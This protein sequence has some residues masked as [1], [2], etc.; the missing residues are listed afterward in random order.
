MDSAE[1][2]DVS[3]EAE[4]SHEGILVLNQPCEYCKVLS[5]DDSEYS[6]AMRQTKT[7][8]PSIDF[9]NALETRLPGQTHDDK[10]HAH[11]QTAFKL[12]YERRD[13]LPDLPGLAATGSQG[14]AF[15]DILRKDI[16]SAWVSPTG[17]SKFGHRDTRANITIT[18]VKYMLQEYGHR[19]QPRDKSD[20]RACLNSLGVFFTIEWHDATRYCLLYYNV[21]A[22]PCDPCTSWFHIRRKPVLNKFSSLITKRRINELIN[23]SLTN[24]AIPESESF[25]P[26]RLLDVGLS[27]TS[28]YIRLIITKQ[29]APLVTEV[30]LESKRYATLSYCWGPKE[31]AA[32]Q[33]KTTR[34]T[35][36]EHLLHI[37][38]KK[39]PQTVADAVQVCRDLQIR[40][41]WVDA[42]CIIQGDEDDW[43]EESYNLFVCLFYY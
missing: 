22:E 28:P 34:D 38:I 40:Y 4:D 42:L 37:D 41:L 2:G 9:G 14:C 1:S 24:D 5:L 3:T 39:L 10:W 18:D 8:N 32:K 25:L 17:R 13:T 36:N 43:S 15:C 31:E 35:I 26:K 6:A 29:H 27:N 20:P 7:E 30:D 33:L 11:E 16:I 21:H 23:K 19:Y 12:E